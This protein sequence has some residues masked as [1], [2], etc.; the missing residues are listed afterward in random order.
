[1]LLII[2]VNRQVYKHFQCDLSCHGTQG[3]L[4]VNIPARKRDFISRYE[5]IVLVIA[6]EDSTG[7]TEDQQHGAPWPWRLWR[8]RPRDRGI[9]WSRATRRA[10]GGGDWRYYTAI[11]TQLIATK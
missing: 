10:V 3:G 6:Q 7:S 5:R 4:F 1:M 8:S 9:E 2:N 11:I